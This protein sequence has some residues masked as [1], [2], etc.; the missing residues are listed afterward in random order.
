MNIKDQF[1]IVT[2]AASGI[3]QEI[4][5]EL[6]R[7][8]IRGLGLVDLNKEALNK[9]ETEFNNGQTMAIALP[10]NTCDPD[11]REGCF[12]VM[13]DVFHKPVNILVPAA[14]ITRDALALNKNQETGEYEIYSQSTFEEVLSIN[15]LAPIYWGLEMSKH[16]AN[17]RLA[18]GLKKWSPEEE[19]QGNI[20]LIGSVSSKGIKGQISY[21]TSKKA[22]S[23]TAEVLRKELMFHGIKTSVVHP[24]FTDTPMVGKLSPDYIEK[25]VLPA[26]QLKRLLKPSEIANSICYCIE[27]DAFMGDLFVDGGWH[28]AP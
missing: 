15:L 28:P 17:K 3:G 19:I 27:N 10:G 25:N 4:A 22:L 2:G 1:A 5:R 20:V 9:L 23:A 13:E 8:E 16:I 18:D 6:V 11:F 14:G 12:V 7:R 24:G 21:S 26:T